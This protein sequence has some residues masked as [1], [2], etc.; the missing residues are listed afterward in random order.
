MTRMTHVR[1]ATREDAE[2]VFE[3]LGDFATNYI[4]E[5][6][7]FDRWY[8]TIMARQ[9]GEF[10]LA[11]G[12]R[13]VVGYILAADI[14]T[15]FANG[16]VTELLELYVKPESRREGIGRRLVERAVRGA[17]QRGA[18]EVTVPT[19]RARDFYLAMG[20]ESTAEYFRLGLAQ[21]GLGEQQVREK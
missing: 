12:D 3:M 17:G 14:P 4:P 5:R 16:L 6:R 1:A 10:L 8:P 21:A 2:A 9:A 13:G 11:D 19:R 20:F 15:L 7:A 18:V